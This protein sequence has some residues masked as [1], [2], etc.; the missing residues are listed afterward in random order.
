MIMPADPKVGSNYRPENIAGLVF[1]EV[2]VKEVGKTV[3]GPRGPVDG[4]IT[5][6]E[7]HDDG[8]TEDKIFAPGYGEFF[9]GSGGDV[10]ALAVAVPTDSLS[11]GVPAPLGT[12]ETGAADIF[13][14]AARGRWNQA[15]RT[16][17][18]MADAWAAHRG[19]G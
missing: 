12:L 17:S 9:T 7:L 1:E 16:S 11:G 3:A 4:A 6:R 19:T 15:A 2:N 8:S 10:E 13:D 14:L 5:V 18:Q